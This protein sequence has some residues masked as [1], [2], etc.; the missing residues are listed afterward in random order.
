M[1]QTPR[2]TSRKQK[3]SKTQSFNKDDLDSVEQKKWLHMNNIGKLHHFIRSFCHS[4]P[5]HVKFNASFHKKGQQM[6]FKKRR[7]VPNDRSH[8]LRPLV[9]IDLFKWSKIYASPHPN[10]QPNAIML[11]HI[12][13]QS[14]PKNMACGLLFPKV[15]FCLSIGWIASRLRVVPCVFKTTQIHHHHG[16]QKNDTSSP[17]KNTIHQK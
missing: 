11:R 16:N 1:Q 15:S 17:Q 3:I 8:R 5:H 4:K 10:S 9:Q 12:L 14:W 6:I 2:K 7:D 13:A